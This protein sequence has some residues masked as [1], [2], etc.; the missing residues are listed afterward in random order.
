MRFFFLITIEIDRSVWPGGSIKE[1][2]S[3]AKRGQSLTKG[4]V[5]FNGRKLFLD[6]GCQTRADQLVVE[7]CIP[8]PYIHEIAVVF[9]KFMGADQNFF[10]RA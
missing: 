5:Q 3:V 1:E 2:M 10:C 7:G 9:V 4:L 6:T 8:Y